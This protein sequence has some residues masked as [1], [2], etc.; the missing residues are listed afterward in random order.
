MRRLLPTRR[1]PSSLS[2]GSGLLREGLQARSPLHES[3][4]TAAFDDLLKRAFSE[5]N[6]SVAI[7]LN[8]RED[9]I[10][11]QLQ[12]CATID[13]VLDVLEDTSR[14]LIIK[15]RGS[16]ASQKLREALKP[17]V[18]GLGILLDVTAET[19]SSLSIPG[20]KGVF[21]AVAMLPS[22]KRPPAQTNSGRLREPQ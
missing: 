10:V 22:G 5:Y 20:G 14:L 9:P 12:E 11:R 1:S 17:V 15:R 18:Y 8:D 19:A 7:D 2:A 3:Y 13:A 21:V 4:P 6:R 16:A